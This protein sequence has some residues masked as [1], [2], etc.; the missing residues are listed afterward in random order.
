MTELDRLLAE[1]DYV[2]L[3]VLLLDS[4]RHMINEPALLK[5]KST[6]CLIN[7]A[8]GPVVDETALLKALNSKVIAVA[9]L[10]V[11]EP[12][13]PEPDNALLQMENVIISPHNAALTDRA[14]WAMAMDSAVTFPP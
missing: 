7:V 8:R 11:F 6:A 14:L 10:D 13:P 4:T 5:M 3:H 1:S 12:K 2:S 9:G